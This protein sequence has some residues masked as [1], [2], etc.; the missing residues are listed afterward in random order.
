MISG[1]NGA[2]KSTLV[3]AGVVRE[4]AGIELISLNAD[5]RAKQL[6]DADPGTADPSL[7]AA[8]EIDALVAACID[9]GVDFLVE[10][11]LSSD[12]YLDDIQRGWRWAIESA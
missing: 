7:R 6:L 9:Q 4:A 8:I 1:P 11:V 2:G 3:E 10:T 12:K 5:V